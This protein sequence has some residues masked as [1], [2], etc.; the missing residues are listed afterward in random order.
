MLRLRVLPPLIEHQLLILHRKRR[1]HASTSLAQRSRLLAEVTPAMPRDHAPLL[2]EHVGQRG[3][4]LDQVL[5]G[6]GSCTIARE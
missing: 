6:A 2:I 4:L 1:Y 3:H 5:G